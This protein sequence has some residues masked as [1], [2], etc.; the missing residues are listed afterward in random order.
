MHKSSIG[1][2]R[3]RF[4]M[5]LTI[6]PPFLPPPSYLSHFE[7]FL[8]GSPSPSHSHSLPWSTRIPI[9]IRSFKLALKWR[10]SIWGMKCSCFP[11]TFSLYSI[12]SPPIPL[13]FFWLPHLT[14]YWIPFADASRFAVLAVPLITYHLSL[15]AP[16][17]V[18]FDCH[19]A[20]DIGSQYRSIRLC[21]NSS[22][23]VR[24][25]SKR[26][27]SLF[28][29]HNPSLTSCKICLQQHNVLNSAAFLFIACTSWI[30]SI[31]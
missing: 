25:S 30:I 15:S 19:V 18:H 12:I 11:R 28:I 13:F 31:I 2:A 7:H 14:L 22:W 20:R 8:S 17:A 27:Y 29:I 24:Q 5:A 10:K 21:N 1:L 9:P 4:S 3:G 6:A 23:A 26:H 16:S